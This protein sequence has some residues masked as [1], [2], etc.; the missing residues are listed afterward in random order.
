M[1]G[2]FEKGRSSCVCFVHKHMSFVC[3]LGLVV[4]EVSVFTRAE[5]EP[6]P[7]LYTTPSKSFGSMNNLYLPHTHTPTHTHTHSK[8]TLFS[9]YTPSGM[10][11]YVTTHISTTCTCMTN[12]SLLELLA[13]LY[14][15]VSEAL[16]QR[17]KLLLDGNLKVRL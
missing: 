12:A 5:P 17:L 7:A 10:H 2:D 3:N 11:F 8:E 1:E 13:C 14:W 6:I 4:Y 9:K 16:I 15:R